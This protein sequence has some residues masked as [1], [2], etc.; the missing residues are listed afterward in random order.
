MEV[1][2]SAVKEISLF[3]LDEKI[4]TTCTSVQQINVQIQVQNSHS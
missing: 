3:D 2:G 1:T 4:D